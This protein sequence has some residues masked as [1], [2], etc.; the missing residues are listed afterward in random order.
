VLELQARIDKEREDIL[1]EIV[2]SLQ[3]Q[4]VKATLVDEPSVDYFGNGSKA[5]VIEL[6]GQSIQKIRLLAFDYGSTLI[7]Y[8][9]QCDILLDKKPALDIKRTIETHTRLVKKDKALGLFGGEVVDVKWVGHE[10]ADQLNAD[11]DL[12]RRLVNHAVNVSNMRLRVYAKSPAQV[13]IIGTD[14]VESLSPGEGES[15]LDTKE[16]LKLFD[17]EIYNR[18][19]QQVRAVLG[20]D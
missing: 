2:S 14:F 19:A 15:L 8:R 17:F 6:S 18:I 13:G 10:L 7:T 20:T 4:G 12:S 16:A 5:S 1:G 11:I 9:F 3:R